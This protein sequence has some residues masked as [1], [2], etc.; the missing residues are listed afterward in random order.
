MP[1]LGTHRF[2]AQNLSAA[3]ETRAPVVVKKQNHQPAKWA[4]QKAEYD[5][6][7]RPSALVF[8]NE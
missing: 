7:E 3:H 4:Q 6:Q 5:A 2:V 1:A 8:A